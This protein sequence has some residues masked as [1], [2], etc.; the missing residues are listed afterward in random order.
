MRREHLIAKLDAV[1][2]ARLRLVVGPAGAG[3]SVLL[4]QLAGYRAEQVVVHCP[5]GTDPAA[6]GRE[7]VAAFG[8]VLPSAAS[9]VDGVLA[10]LARTDRDVVVYIDDAH[11]LAGGPGEAVLARLLTDSAPDVRFVVATRDARVPGTAAVPGGIHR[12]G[13]RDLRLR[14]WDVEELFESVYRRPLSPETAAAL[15]ARVEGLPMAVRLLHLDT[16]LLA[17]HEREAALATPLAGSE[18][19]TEFLS[20]E[21]LG[22]LPAPLRDFMV[23][24]SPLG[25]LDGALCDAVLDRRDSGDVLTELAARQALTFRTRPGGSTYRF[26]VLLQQFLE[27]RLA[28]HR[29]THLTRQ[30]YHTAATHLVSAGHWAEAYRCYARADD[31]V[32]T[33]SVLHRFSAHRGG[34]R[35][36]ASVPGTLLDDD[37]WMA[38]A[39]AR[40]LRGE[41]RLA[42]A[43]DRY[44]DAEDKLPDPRLRWQCSLERSGIARWI[45]GGDGDPLVDDVSRHLAAAVHGHPAKLLA[46]AVP[47]AGPDWALGR[48]LAAMLDGRPDQAIALAEPL[49]TDPT[50]F[51]S[52]AGRL[53][54]A[55]LEATTH[56]RGTLARFTGLATDAEATG[57][58]WLARIARAGTALLDPE[59][60]TDAQAILDECEEIGDEWGALITASLLATGLLRAGSQ[61]TAGVL[62]RA[63]WRARRLGARVPETWLRLVLVDELVR[64][65]DPDASNER[66]E[67]DRLIKATVLDRAS[68][69][70]TELVAALRVPSA[71]NRPR[72]ALA[73][74]VPEPEPPVAVRCLGRYELAVAGTP[75]D[76][77]PL[78]AQARR[79][80]RV[81]S[82]HYGQP[83]HEERL[84]A[85]L[86]PDAPLKQAKHRLQVA[87]SSLR[88]L[89][90]THLAGMG[91]FGV[92]RHGS[93]YLL[94]LPPGSTVD[95]ADFAA[96]VRQWRD[97]RHT[98]D[99]PTVRALGHR[100]LDLYRGELLSEEGPAE[101]VLAR[102]E[103]MRGEA[104]G[105]A[106]ALARIELDRGDVAAAIEVC[107][108]A[109][110]I[111]ELDNRLWALLAEARRRSGNTAAALRTQQAYRDLLA[112]G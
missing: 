72:L 80:L 18:R 9:D 42:A 23:D 27:Q 3:K 15:C 32:A 22:A 10:D 6:F 40:R 108:R 57:W 50:T 19:L 52:L 67:L 75:V 47:A 33:A 58:L 76:L 93:A 35:A 5:V 51:V 98:Q 94:L 62:C 101:W 21:V 12:I 1:S 48:A 104:A 70:G 63:V 65:G 99:R 39:E 59:A 79:V 11:R 97:S 36:S 55:V 37:P 88:A 81:L 43:H 100:V 78:R 102:R 26:H 24:V 106:A 45:T 105:V 8:P 77:D 73:Q 54:V 34:L 87:I 83:L 109:L 89:L 86:W 7:L 107:D 17:P 61:T 49:T 84:V 4:R 74:P 31:W 68:R 20:R 16:M 60:C 110:T 38:L 111:D 30:T 46:R 90:R 91:E 14:T 29:G 41:G 95:V 112:E 69:H 44:L 64:L 96:A 53:V 82:M 25:V 103:S 66:A 71:T 13:Y 92:M 2:A 28:E 85:A 56:S